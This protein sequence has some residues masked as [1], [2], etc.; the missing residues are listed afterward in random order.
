LEFLLE[1]LD[2]IWNVYGS[3]KVGKGGAFERLMASYLRTAPEFSDRFDEVYLWQDWPERGAMHDHGIDIVAKDLHTGGWCAVQCKFYD[4]QH[5]VS[6]AD[7][8]SFLAASA[9]KQFTGRIIVSTAKDWGPDG[10]SQLDGLTVPVTRIGSTTCSSPRS[11][12]RQIDWQEPQTETSPTHRQEAAPPAPARGQG[13]RPSGPRDPR[14]RPADHGLRHRQDLHEPQDRRAARDRQ[15]GEAD[16]GPLP[17]PEHPAGQPDVAGVEAGERDAVPCLRRLLRRQGRQERPDPR[18]TPRTSPS[19]TSSIPATT[20][21]KALAARS[22]SA[23]D[24]RSRSSS[25][26]T[27]R[28]TSSPRR[29]GRGMPDFDLIIC[30]EAHRTTGVT[31]AGEDES[32]FV[33]STTTPTSAARSGST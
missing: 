3:D 22:A 25:R 23:R 21:T 32:Q 20:D 7:I 6:K 31:L 8:D 10:E 11:T 16:D 12:G 18:T 29:N 13:R 26:P 27:S 2:E 28:S 1:K 4:P 15:Q 33:R 24:D 19:T 30:D 17:R 5:H 9:K 14:P